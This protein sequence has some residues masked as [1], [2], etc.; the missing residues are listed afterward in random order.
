[1]SA[2]VRLISFDAGGVLLFPDFERVSQAV[3]RAGIDVSPAA[4]RKAD[5]AAKYAMDHPVAAGSTNNAG[6]ASMYFVGLLRGAGVPDSVDLEAALDAVRD[7]NAAR[8]LWSWTPPEVAPMLRRLS[9]AGLPLIVVSNS[10]GRLKDL[11]QQVGLAGHFTLVVDSK[12]VGV[13]KP[14]PAIFLGALQALG[15]SAD[16]AAHV[17]DFFTVDV[18]GARAAGMLPVLIDPDQ[19]HEGRD[20]VRVRDYPELEAYLMRVAARA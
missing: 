6:H 4:L 19:L 11:L 15:V 14:D 18:L 16:E 17:G 8:N 7:E 9:A 2:A 13:E 12:D 10:D 5:A 20:C 1:M 3:A